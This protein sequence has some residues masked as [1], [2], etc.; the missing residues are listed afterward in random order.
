[1]DASDISFVAEN[2]YTLDI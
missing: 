1:L 2:C